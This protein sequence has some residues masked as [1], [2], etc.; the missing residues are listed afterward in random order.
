MGRVLADRFPGK[1]FQ[2]SPLSLAIDF[3]LRNEG[4]LFISVD[5]SAP[6]I[7]LIKRTVRELEK[8][9]ISPSPFVQ[10]LRAKAGSGKLHSVAKY[11][12]ERIVR[13]SFMTTDDLGD[14]EPWDLVVQ[15]TGRSAN[16]FL[17]NSAGIITHAL[18]APKGAGQQIGD[19]YQP[20]PQSSSR[21]PEEKEPRISHDRA[22]TISQACDEHYRDLD[23]RLD[24]ELAAK[25]LLG[26]LR[27][28]ITKL[29][30]L[31]TNLK[32]DLVAHGNAE[33]HK[34]FGDLLLANISTAERHGNTVKLTDYY[35]DNAPTIELEVDENMSLQDAAAEYFSRYGK[36]KRAV[37]EIDTRLAEIERELDKLEARKLRMEEAIATGDV[38]ALEEFSEARAKP[39]AASTGQKEGCSDT[40]RSAPLSFFRWI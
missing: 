6:R 39:V 8:S 14:E 40:S 5:P 17:L 27:K 25:N 18:R 29:R 13:L 11:P 22:I 28:E 12:N 4:Y 10:A 24:F 33:E 21:S 31:K 16:L 9:S 38:S 15:L 36:S 26:K 32:N 19:A 1:I 20:P 34:R 30:K 37:E 2:F 7:Y 23:A 35:A 3:R